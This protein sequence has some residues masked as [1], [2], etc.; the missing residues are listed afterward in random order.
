MSSVDSD[1]GECYLFVKTSTTTTHWSNDDV[2]ICE[3]TAFSFC[4]RLSLRLCNGKISSLLKRWRS[5]WLQ[6][7]VLM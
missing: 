4:Y 6:K 7:L 1:M 3:Q 5:F 2:L